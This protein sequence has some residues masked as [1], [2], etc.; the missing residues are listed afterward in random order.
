M[1]LV[2]DTNI[3]TSALF[4]DGPRRR[5][6]D[7]GSEGKATLFTSRALLAE[8]RAVLSRAKFDSRIHEA[9]QTVDN[10]VEGYTKQT[11]SVL[12]SPTPRIVTDPDDDVAIG[13]ALAAE[14]DLIVTGD[15][16]LL[17]VAEYEDIL[18]VSPVEA[19][20]LITAG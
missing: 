6:S 2:L 3:V 12:P 8:L 9:R 10:L 15:K 5:V 13:T 4:W 7:A 18:I 11:V 17:L 14:A 20:R 19:L 16:A 1:R